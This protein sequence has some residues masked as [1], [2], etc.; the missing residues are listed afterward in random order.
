MNTLY[1]LGKPTKKINY[2]YNYLKANL[3]IDL[4]LLKMRNI[5]VLY[6]IKVIKKFK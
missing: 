2:Q 5:R 4:S 6:S 1:C 3:F